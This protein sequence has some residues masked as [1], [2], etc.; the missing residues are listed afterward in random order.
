MVR[1]SAAYKR[2]AELISL[3]MPMDVAGGSYV[4]VGRPFDGGYVMLDNFS[5]NS[6]AAAYSFGIS[7]DVSWD[8]AIAAR[9]IDVFLFDQSLSLSISTSTPRPERGGPSPLWR[10]WSERGCVRICRSNSVHCSNDVIS[11]SE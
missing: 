11:L 9:A 10:L 1:A 2:C 4:R 5:G 8:E 7:N 3:L 6:K